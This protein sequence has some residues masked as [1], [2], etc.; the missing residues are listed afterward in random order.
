MIRHS[1]IFGGI[2]SADFNV[3][4]SGSGTFS[5]PTRSVEVVSVPGRNGDLIIDN[6]KW[7]NITVTYPAFIPSGFEA[8]IDA[9]RTAISRLTGYQKLED[10]YHPD[11]YRMA[12]L[13][14]GINPT[15]IGAFLK[16]GEFTISFNCKPQRFLKSGDEPIQIIP[17]RL[18]NGTMK[19]NYFP[20]S[21][22]RPVTFELKCTQGDTPSVKVTSYDANLT[23]ITS[24]T[25]TAYNGFKQSYTPSSSEAYWTLQVSNWSGNTPTLTIK[26]DVTFGSQTFAVNAAMTDTVK[27]VNP[28]GY[29]SKPL[30]EFRD[31][32]IQ[33]MSIQNM[34]EIDGATEYTDYFQLYSGDTETEH[35]FLDCDIQYMYD[36]FHNNLTQYLFLVDSQTVQGKSL[37]F[38]E[39]GE[40][41]EISF[42][43]LPAPQSADA[44]I[45]LLLLYPRW[46]RL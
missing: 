3:F 28:T 35:F 1:F 42:G 29:R 26:T 9:F 20:A 5:A 8:N 2:N 46:W 18:S 33:N 43:G 45:G 17:P 16:N 31:N 34:V 14:G 19:T 22:S 38:P 21:P 36:D 13:V 15:K 44:S 23:Q 30:M 32:R 39:L 41:T 11:E 25:Y 37:V 4:I 6:G 10:T 40:M 7:N 12:A 27:L 24:G